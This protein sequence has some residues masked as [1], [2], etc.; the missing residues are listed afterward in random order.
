MNYVDGKNLKRNC[1]GLDT[2]ILSGNGVKGWNVIGDLG[3]GCPKLEFL[4]LVGN[5]V[6]SKWYNNCFVICFGWF[7]CLENKREGNT[8]H[9]SVSITCTHTCLPFCF[10][11]PAVKMLK[12]IIC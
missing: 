10:S 7:V 2:V 5:P 6:T 1:P 11:S 9:V 3:V 12:L 4:S 8:Y